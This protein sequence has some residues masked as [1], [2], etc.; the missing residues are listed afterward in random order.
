MITR[1]AL[2]A[3]GAG[4][5]LAG[6]GAEAEPV[7]P[8]AELLGAVLAAERAL[9]GAYAL[10][11]GRT[12]GVLAARAR[13]HAA[14]LEQAGA[15]P[16]P[17]PASPAGEPLEAA[18]ALQRRSMAACVSAVGVVRSP[19]G[20]TLAADVLTA[21]AQHAAILLT[22]LGRDPVPTAFPRGQAP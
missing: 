14:R 20:R 19:A 11:E 1:R 16:A 10:L 3:A 8:D 15:D 13:S 17:A 18:L 9:A 5:L 6:C 7:P 12:G 2:V 21:G 4:V 22:R